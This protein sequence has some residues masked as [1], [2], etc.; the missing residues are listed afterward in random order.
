MAMNGGNGLGIAG[1]MFAR[2]V[3]GGPEADRVHP[4]SGP[5]IL[6]R[7]G[8]RGF[9]RVGIYGSFAEALKAADEEVGLGNGTPED[10]EL[11]FAGK[12]GLWTRIRAKMHL[13]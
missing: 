4:K 8:D 5:W 11:E 9:H 10:Y 7:R 1:S 12:P 2:V 6:E 3:V 13:R